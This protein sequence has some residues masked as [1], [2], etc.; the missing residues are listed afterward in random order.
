MGRLCQIDTE[1]RS[2]V[3]RLLLKNGVVPKL[4][5]RWRHCSR[6]LSVL[7][8]FLNLRSVCEGFCI[9]SRVA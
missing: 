2:I 8:E 7:P 1:A 4:S 6:G 3:N 5:S 9:A